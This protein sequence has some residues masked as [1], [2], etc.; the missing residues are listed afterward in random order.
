MR[1]PGPAPEM[2]PGVAAPV[3]EGRAWR[4]RTRQA[5]PSSTASGTET[6]SS[7]ISSGRFGSVG[8]SGTLGAETS[9]AATASSVS[10]A[11]PAR[12]CCARR[13]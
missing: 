4:S 7:A 13:S 6:S 3:P 2:E 10:S 9:R 8:A 12:W 5:A 1:P 11:S